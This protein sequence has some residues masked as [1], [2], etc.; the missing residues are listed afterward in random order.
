MF[1]WL[2][3]VWIHLTSQLFCLSWLISESFLFCVD[4]FKCP[5]GNLTFFQGTC[6]ERW[7]VNVFYDSLGLTCR[8]GVEVDDERLPG[9][10][11]GFIR[12]VSLQF[13]ILIVLLDLQHVV[14]GDDQRGEAWED[15]VSVNATS[16]DGWS[17][18]K[19]RRIAPC[20][21]SCPASC[22]LDRNKSWICQICRNKHKVRVEARR[23]C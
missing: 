20:S 13:R 14:P 4:F 2:Q 5:H 15:V 22:S 11:F 7:F 3:K 10:N 9:E 17:T 23:S 18:C 1:F 19:Y 16:C 21:S 6:A 8:W 12:P